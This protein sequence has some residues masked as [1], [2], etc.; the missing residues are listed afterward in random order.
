MHALGL[1][2]A[3]LEEA[4]DPAV[5][6]GLIEKIA[7]SSAAI[8]ELLD[9]LL[10]ISRL[11]AGTIE[12]QP[13]EFALQPLFER[14]EQAF[15]LAAQSKELRLRVRPTRLCVATDPLLLERILLNLVSNAVRYTKTGGVLL[16]A[17]RRGERVSIEVWD[18]G[19]GIPR[20]EQRRIFEEFYRLPGS[21]DG[22]SQGLGLGLAIVE[23]LARL[24]D[25]PLSVASVVGRGSKFA[26]SVL[27]A[28]AAAAEP[29]AAPHLAVP[30][31][32]EGV[33]VL[34]IDDDAAA[35][36]A[37][38]GLFVQWGCRVLAAA[39][40]GEA[41]AL[42][43]SGEARPAVILCD[44]RLGEDEL[45]TA[46]IE[47]IRRRLA[48]EIPAVLVSGDVTAQLRQE[49]AAAGLHLLPKPLKAAKLRALLH[50]VCSSAGQGGRVHPERIT[51]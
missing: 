44:Y 13:A 4:R 26:L 11:D 25:L 43:A 20:E 40:G 10:D 50:H 15:G 33:T 9:A 36:D 48:A 7:A 14:M 37:A 3:Q 6:R 34:V 5:I 49:V 27:L 51:E 24:L 41:E 38:Q 29:S 28:R 2:I 19:A 8:S 31:A 21:G 39:S 17:R 12:P 42:L 1:F 32:F 46:V 22:R 35:R 23:R 18:T 30:A 16:A 45:G 47:R